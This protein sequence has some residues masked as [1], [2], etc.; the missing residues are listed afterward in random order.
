VLHRFQWE[1]AVTVAT[2]PPPLA[3]PRTPTLISLC[4][5]H[6]S[7]PWADLPTDLWAIQPTGREVMDFKK[8]L[9]VRV[10]KEQVACILK[11]SKF[12]S[13]ASC[14]LTNTTLLPLGP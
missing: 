14:T 13:L 5:T 1:G 11:I 2:F 12:N 10:N 3:L 6:L 7:R 4:K 9:S 8:A